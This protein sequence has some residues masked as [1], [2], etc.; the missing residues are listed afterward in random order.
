MALAQ[1]RN[2][3]S[4]SEWRRGIQEVDA[5]VFQHLRTG[6]E[7]G[8]DEETFAQRIGFGNLKWCRLPLPTRNEGPLARAPHEASAV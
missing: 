2:V 3:S 4:S 1:D 8:F 5:A 7:G 6:I